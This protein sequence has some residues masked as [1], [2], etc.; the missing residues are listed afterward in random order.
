[1]TKKEKKEEISEEETQKKNKISKQEKQVKW[2]IIITIIVILALI[3]TYWA[4]KWYTTEKSYFNYLGVRWDI[5]NEGG[6]TSYRGEFSLP[7]VPSFGLY[8]TND[9]RK[10]NVSIEVKDWGFYKKVITSYDTELE[11]CYNAVLAQ[12]NLVYFLSGGLRREVIPGMFNETQAQERNITFA[13]CF[14]AKNQ[15]VIMIRKSEVPSVYQSP[16]S[17]DCYVINVGNCE[18]LLATEKFMLGVITFLKNKTTS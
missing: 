10:N 11:K 15:T 14:T 1:M 3:G 12:V 4:I 2:V 5:T 16:L 6:K 8:L 18:N 17:R 13:D 7:N 9:P